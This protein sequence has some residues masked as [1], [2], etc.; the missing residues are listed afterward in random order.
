M[1]NLVYIAAVFFLFSCT[2]NTIYEKPKDLI[3]KDTMVSLLTDMYLAVASKQTKNI[4]LQKDINYMFLVYEKYNID[5][6]RFRSSN[7]YYTTII[8]EY[9]KMYD[10]IIKNLKKRHEASKILEKISDSIKRDSLLMIKTLNAKK[11]RLG[12]KEELKPLKKML[13]NPE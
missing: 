3:P 6:T 7:Y 9:E 11:E 4:H 8:E 2:S 13:K 10:T 1:K 5:S 12:K